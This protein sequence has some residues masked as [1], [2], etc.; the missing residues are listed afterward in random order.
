[1]K[2]DLD[3][4][5]DQ[6]PADPGGTEPKSQDK[7]EPLLSFRQLMMPRDVADDITLVDRNTRISPWAIARWL[8]RSPEGG[9]PA[10]RCAAQKG[11]SLRPM[12]R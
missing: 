4:K 8:H 1:M 10:G 3:K 5:E 9:G 7:K 12:E 6:L 11:N 2:E